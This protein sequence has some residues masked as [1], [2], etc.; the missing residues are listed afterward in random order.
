MVAATLAYN[1]QSPQH[2]CGLLIPALTGMRFFLTSNGD[3][4]TTARDGEPT[5]FVLLS[6]VPNLSEDSE[7]K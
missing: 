7:Q 6:A 5:A 4:W 2:D 3:L 1:L